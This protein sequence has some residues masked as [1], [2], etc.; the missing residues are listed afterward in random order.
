MLHWAREE[1]REV[2][3]S[4]GLGMARLGDL[5]KASTF[6]KFLEDRRQGILLKMCS[7]LETG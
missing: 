7:V 1:P 2:W 3:H 4:S 5:L 6:L